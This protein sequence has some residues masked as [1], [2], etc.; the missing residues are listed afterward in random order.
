[1]TGGIHLNG[2]Q[3]QTIVGIGG[4]AADII[5]ACSAR[6]VLR[7]SNPGRIRISPG[8]VTRNI[9]ENLA[10]QGCGVTM[11]SAVGNDPFGKTVT[12]LSAAAGL[13]MT[14]V[15]VSERMPTACYLAVLDET[16]DMFVGSSDFSVMTELSGDYL[17]GCAG[18]IRSASAVVTDANLSPDILKRIVALAGEVPVFLDPV[19]E[20]KIC[21]IKDLLGLFHTVKPNR[22]E[23]AVATGIPCDTREGLEKAC[24]ALLE[25]G[26]REVV[27]SLGSEGCFYKN[28]DGPGIYRKLREKAEMKNATGAGDAFVAGYVSGFVRGLDVPARLDRALAAGYIAVM[29][30]ETINPEMSDELIHQIILK[31]SEQ[32]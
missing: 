19:S 3:S 4:M 5:S 32:R 8:G 27:V 24:S 26:C 16:G 7:D 18:V 31:Y 25:Q 6:V 15:L 1:M 17:N 9:C 2:S 28:V 29:G 20:A 22:S 11:L 30:S 13:D 14:H 21:I 10:R 23:L 12:E